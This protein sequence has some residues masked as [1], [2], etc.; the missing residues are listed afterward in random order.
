MN[1][2]SL[3]DLSDGWETLHGIQKGLAHGRHTVLVEGLPVAAKA[4]VLARLL[5]D[6]R[7]PTLILTYSDEQAARLAADLTIYLPEDAAPVRTLPSSL[8]L[9][10]DDEESVRDVGRAGRRCATLISLANGGEFSALIAVTPAL[11]QKTP[12]P[13]SLKNR[14]LTF[15]VGQS[16]SLDS[17]AIRLN[18][19]GY[20]RED[21]VS[22]PGTFARRGDILDIYPADADNPVRIDLFGDDIESIRLFDIESQRS[23][24]KIESVTVAA[25]HEVIFTRESIS[26]SVATLREQLQ[27]R[28]TVMEK[29]HEDAQRIE[30]LR[31]SAEGDIARIGQAAYFAGIERYL[32]LLHPGVVSA[33]DYLPA[34]LMVVIDEPAQMKSHAE[35]DIDGVLK[36]LAG[37][38]ERGEILPVAD[39]LCVDFEEGIRQATR[40]RPI[41]YFEL[42][43]RSLSFVHAE[44]SI[45]AQAGNAETFAGRSAPFLD[46]LATYARNHV[47]V[48]IVSAQAP[49]VRGILSGREITEVPLKTLTS[50]SK[51]EARGGVALVNGVLPSGFKITDARLVV[52]TDTEIFGTPADKLKSNRKR[53]FRDG[54]RITSLLD[55]KEGDFVVHINHGIGLYRGLTRMKAGG[56]EKEYLEI[57][58]EGSDKL[59]VSVDQVDR[60][61]KY[62]GSEGMAPPLNKLGGTEWARTTAKAQRQVREIAKDLIELYAARFSAVGHSYSED[63]PWQREMEDSFPYTETPDQMVAINDVKKDLEQPR[64]M[65]RLICGDV[66]FGK[67]EVAMRAAFKVAS[68]GRQVAVLCPTTV[69]CAQHFQTFRERMA[70]FPIRI[71]MLSRFRSP[72]EQAKT[73][74]DIKNG[75]VDI[76]I[77]THRLLSKDVEFKDL[78]LVVVDE[79]QRFGVTHK[80][81]LKQLRKT[82]DVLSMSATP[83]P[84]TLQMSLSGIRD[85][86]LINDPP[87]G[88]TPVKTLIKE[89]DDALVREAILREIDRGGQVYYIHNRVESIYH[90]AHHLEKIVP[91][92][93][94]RVG[95]GQM[96]EDSLE[97]TMMAFYQ[98]EFDVL[99]CTT[100]VESGLDIPNVNT[101]LIDNSDKFGLSQLYQLRGRVGRSRTQA[102]AYLLYQRNKVLSTIAEQRLGAVRE[103]SDLGSGYKIALRDLELRGAGNLLGAEQSG[104]VA[105]IGFDLYMQLLEQAVREMKGEEPSKQDIL[106]PTVDLPVAAVIPESYIPAEPQRIL[107][108][109][110]LSAV[111]DR[112][113]VARLQEEFEDR[114]GDPPP[115][116]W[117]A[118]SLIRL[119][120][121]CQE[122]GIESI[123]TESP[124]ITLQFKKGVKLPLHTI[125][126]LMAAFKTQ[127]HQFTPEQ[128]ILTIQ[129]SQILRM[130]E[131][132]VEVIDRALKEPAPPPSQRSVTGRDR[133]TLS[134]RR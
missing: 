9:L 60:V 126:P 34:D 66:G 39:P 33:L 80:E 71:D 115:P 72:K 99:V 37:R 94:F 119:R 6:S 5:R 23:E 83:I 84:R 21:Q 101:I 26:R 56:V 113:D 41:L 61:Q 25:A 131:E 100:I 29:A 48:V 127:K 43:A 4:W 44:M 69:L 105:Q 2:S 11:L 129:G 58:Y 57:Q 62:I 87:E 19:F 88:R 38:A 111:R 75:S 20:T 32:T 102:Y 91:S 125:K 73:I 109:K 134:T 70:P 15:T 28:V 27:K 98:K 106:L 67:T 65:D 14:F 116:V 92:A 122:L 78:G 31:E 45:G 104:T 17:V 77:G 130:V 86:S 114:F 89:Y 12:P 55:L 16:I 108:Y 79:E 42:L 132:M 120:L 1:L 123:T 54:M 50:R 63:T 47:R 107:M 52:L 110:K 85:M 59:F 49:R 74:E 95:H 90:V 133:R 68:E 7:K 24:G 93:R 121:R 82:V 96:N 64:P 112:V 51:G 3:L 35:R 128:V 46:A 53:E 40:N 117:N 36:N 103:F 97:D 124:R 76:V 10:L 18:A 81:R 8:P 30:R 13:E 22:L 118:L